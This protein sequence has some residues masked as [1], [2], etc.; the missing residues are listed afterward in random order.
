M[1]TEM[2]TLAGAQELERKLK[3]LPTKVA[4]KAV[5]QAVRAGGK[6]TLA[7]AKANA[8]ALVGGTMGGLIAAN[9]VLRAQR[10]QRRGSYG[11]NVMM[12][13]KRDELFVH[14]SKAGRR[15]YIPAAIEY[16]HGSARPI[17]F[18]RTGWDITK[19]QAK[20]IVEQ[21]LWSGIQKAAKE[22]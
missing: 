19:M 21:T 10:R 20:R 1:A 7:Q 16:G 13:P 6:P 5:R 22:A 17:S 4:K 15:T 3:N 12:R 9:L 2:M 14:T 11:V 18:M 8:S